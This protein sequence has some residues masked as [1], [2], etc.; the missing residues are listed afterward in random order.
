M[1]QAGAQPEQGGLPFV[2]RADEEGTVENL[3]DPDDGDAG[4]DRTWRTRSAWSTPVTEPKRKRLRSPLHELRWLLITTTARLRKPTNRMPIEVSSGRGRR[5]HPHH[6]DAG[7]HRQ[8]GDGEGAEGGVAAEHEHDSDA[9]QD[10]VGQRIAE[11]LMPPRS[12]TQVPTRAGAHGGEEHH[13][14]W[15]HGRC[16]WR[17]TARP[18]RPTGR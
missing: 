16:R 9:G 10:A 11:R 17:G 4:G 12:T 6:V 5:G 8:G 14:E 15:R 7:H 3:D 18:T 1:G 2:E 13:R